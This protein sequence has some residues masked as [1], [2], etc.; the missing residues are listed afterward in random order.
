MVVYWQAR[1]TL[2]LMQDSLE[3]IETFR[4]EQAGKLSDYRI[5]I[6]CMFC[7]VTW[8]DFFG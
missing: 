2:G 4:L 3:P 7:I 6:V 8:V 5:P 1:N